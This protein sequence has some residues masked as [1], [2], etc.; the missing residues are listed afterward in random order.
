MYVIPAIDLMG[1]KAVRLLKGEKDEV[2]VY[3]DD[4][5]SLAKQFES[6]GASQLH[7]VDLDA[8]FGENDNRQIIKEIVGSV[9]M[10][11][12][13]GGGIRDM[14]YLESLMTLGVSRAIIGTAAFRD[15]AFFDSALKRFGDRIALSFDL[16][17]GRVAIRGWVEPVEGDPIAILQDFQS[18]GLKYIIY[19]DISRDG[20]L[21]GPDVEGTATIAAMT[22]I[23][24]I[25]S[26]G[27]S[28]L[29]DLK[30]LKDAGG[31]YGAITGKAVYEKKFTV[32]DAVALIEND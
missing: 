6:E 23:N 32:K 31:I 1:G 22:N 9:N 13:V 28:S 17:D 16:K 8:A 29:V 30:A 2:T 4:P 26:G 11:V 7:I 19:T 27:V 12:E 3:S 20:T 10:Q 25:A 21:A 5:V 14:D 18:K 15:H 24:V